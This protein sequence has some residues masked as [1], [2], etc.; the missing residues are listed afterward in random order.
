M[1]QRE[2]IVNNNKNSKIIIYI[3]EINLQLNE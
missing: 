3:K 2:I 1:E